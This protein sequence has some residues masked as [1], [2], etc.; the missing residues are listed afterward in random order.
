[1]AELD[2]EHGSAAELVAAADHA[3]LRAKGSGVFDVPQPQG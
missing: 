1:V 3:L 2:A